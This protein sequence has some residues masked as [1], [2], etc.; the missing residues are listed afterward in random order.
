M[1]T[2][3]SILE[4]P[5]QLVWPDGEPLRVWQVVVGYVVLGVCILLALAAF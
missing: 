5:I 1:K 3:R 2:L 4:A